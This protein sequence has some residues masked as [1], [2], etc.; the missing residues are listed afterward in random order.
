M[1][2][3]A[4][5]AISLICG[6]SV[7]AKPMR[8][9]LTPA[10][11]AQITIGGP[12][13]I[14]LEPSFSWRA[15]T[16]PVPAPPAGTTAVR[17]TAA[18]A[19]SVEKAFCNT[20]GGYEVQGWAEPTA[21]VEIPLFWDEAD[22]WPFG[23]SGPSF[24]A[25]LHG[26]VID[27]GT[28]DCDDF[29]LGYYDGAVEEV[30]SGNLKLFTGQGSDVELTIGW[31]T[32]N[33]THA[34]DGTSINDNTA[35]DPVVVTVEYLMIPGMTPLTLDRAAPV[36]PVSPDALLSTLERPEVIEEYTFPLHATWPE[37]AY[38]LNFPTAPS[39]TTTVEI[40]VWQSG[41]CEAAFYNNDGQVRASVMPFF[42]VV[43]GASPYVFPLAAE[44]T[45]E[46]NANGFIV[47]PAADD[48][49]TYYPGDYE[50]TVAKRLT[51]NL[52][53]FVDPD[54][55]VNLPIA[56]GAANRGNVFGSSISVQGTSREGTITIRYLSEP[57]EQP[58]RRAP[59]PV[60][61]VDPE[62][63][64]RLLPGREN[65]TVNGRIE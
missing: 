8:P 39:G 17:I 30:L 59:E 46:F 27:P 62:T 28:N 63:L 55:E 9:T 61:P 53:L 64:L 24:S 3:A 22:G 60:T 45:M 31:R 6:V 42:D 15:E 44:A 58:I 40:E 21:E 12:H 57:G 32:T 37:V 47:S 49:D 11:A 56:E 13:T 26:T 19:G 52:Y 33:F 29:R 16:F 43:V 14:V 7:A 65:V 20:P 54:G 36:K 23:D 4:C 18:G 35:I 41:S 34:T 10:P 50:Q 48:E 2:L 1:I 38:E 5:A 25:R 51:A